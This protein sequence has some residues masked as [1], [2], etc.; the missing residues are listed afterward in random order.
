MVVQLLIL[1]VNEWISESTHWIDY[2]NHSHLHYQFHSVMKSTSF[3]ASA[4]YHVRP[5][6]LVFHAVW[7]LM[8][9]VYVLHYLKMTA[10]Q[11][12]LFCC[13]YTIS[14]PLSSHT[15]LGWF[16]R[17]DAGFT[18]IWFQ[19]TVLFGSNRCSS[20]SNSTIYRFDGTISGT[21][22]LKESW[23]VWAHAD[24]D[25]EAPNLFNF[26]LNPA[27]Q[28]SDATERVSSP[29]S[30]PSIWLR[31]CMAIARS[32]WGACR[33]QPECP[34]G[35]GPND[36][37]GHDDHQPCSSTSCPTSSSHSWAPRSSSTPDCGDG[38]TAGDG[39]IGQ[40]GQS[41]QSCS[42]RTILAR[43]G[44]QIP[45]FGWHQLESPHRGEHH[46]AGW[47]QRHRGHCRRHQFQWMDHHPRQ[48]GDKSTCG[49]FP[50]T[51]TSTRRHR[52]AIATEMLLCGSPRRRNP[53]RLFWK[54]GRERSQQCSFFQ[55]LTTSL[56]VQIF[57]PTRTWNISPRRSSKIYALTSG[58]RK[59]DPTG[60]TATQGRT[61]W[62]WT[63]DSPSSSGKAGSLVMELHAEPG[64]DGT[65]QQ[66]PPGLSDAAP[67][68]ASCRGNA[69]EP[70]GQCIS[71]Q[72]PLHVNE[73]D[74]V[75]SSRGCGDIFLAIWSEL[76]HHG[77]NFTRL[78]VRLRKTILI[79][80]V[81]WFVNRFN[82]NNHIWSIWRIYIFCSQNSWRQLRKCGTRVV[83]APILIILVVVQARHL[84]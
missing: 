2:K 27:A 64:E 72:R 29:W 57:K 32:V 16:T 24:H 43:G 60:S 25:R 55:W 75:P 9:V 10:V 73:S 77:W 79:W 40:G 70:S 62:S 44:V 4:R 8:D 65:G 80:L 23:W 7:G 54:C 46:P 31:S 76:K 45:N 69:S 17:F 56:S 37:A 12:L 3:E 36:L 26:W 67:F 52:S 1:D 81:S 19:G 71:S 30:S 20:Y 39:P 22:V 21:T 51:W 82:Y 11:M 14:S 28:D 78:F 34:P 59:K 6:W 13:H 35:L 66:G 33:E 84:I 42:T 83:L 74:A 68:P 18:S 49:R 48:I 53:D 50:R 61:H 5:S 41:T 47:H 63:Q 38:R 58:L 15:S